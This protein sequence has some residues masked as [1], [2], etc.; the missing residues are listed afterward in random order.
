[1]KHDPAEPEWNK[2]KLVRQ[3]DEILYNVG[4]FRSNLDRVDGSK[5]ETVSARLFAANCELRKIFDCLKPVE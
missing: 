2:K 5:I 1:M 4:Y 3:L